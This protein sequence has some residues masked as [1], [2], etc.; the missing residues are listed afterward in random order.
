[1]NLVKSNAIWF[2]VDA[3]NA[4]TRGNVEV[5]ARAYGTFYQSAKAR[6]LA[7]LQASPVNA[8]PRSAVWLFKLVQRDTPLHRLLCSAPGDI[9]RPVVAA[10]YLNIIFWQYRH[11]F[12]GPRSKPDE[13]SQLYQILDKARRAKTIVALV[14]WLITDTE[15]YRIHHHHSAWLLAR[16]MRVESRLSVHLQRVLH[17]T[18]VQFLLT[19]E[20]ESLEPSWLTPEQFRS[21]VM[22]DLNFE[23]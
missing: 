16:L 1:M 13:L 11:H 10:L 12:A 2:S 4:I 23:H 5:L 8:P 3:S 21:A 14:W 9:V 18:L 22:T 7:F 6:S 19:D 17:T 20:I 15:S